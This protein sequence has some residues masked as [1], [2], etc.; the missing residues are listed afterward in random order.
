MTGV[1]PRWAGRAW[2]L[3]VT[4]VV[5]CMATGN[6]AADSPL[7]ADRPGFSFS[8]GTVAAGRVVAETGY[9]YTDDNTGLHQFPVTS[10]RVG[11]RDGLEL[12]LDWGGH[13]W[14]AANA[15]PTGA[16]VVWRW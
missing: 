10:V 6:V 1:L 8:A 4:L 5:T 9:Q 16:G 12:R 15:A 7:N 11:V 2:L 14:S 13:N 3:A